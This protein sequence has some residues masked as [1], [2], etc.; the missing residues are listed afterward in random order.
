MRNAGPAGSPGDAYVHCS[1]RGGALNLL[2]HHM[3]VSTDAV[4][5]YTG[6]SRLRRQ[7]DP[8]G[9]TQVGQN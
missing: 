4:P 3:R 2:K 5:S 7:D 8:P 6:G 9:V 1:V